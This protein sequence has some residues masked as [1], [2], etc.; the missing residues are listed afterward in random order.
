MLAERAQGAGTEP[1]VGHAARRDLAIENA[2]LAAD[3]A[4]GVDQAVGRDGL[5]ALERGEH[6]ALGDARGGEVEDDRRRGLDR[7]ADRDRVG[8]EAPVDAAER[9]HDRPRH[10]RHEM[11]RDQ[12]LGGRHLRVVADAAEM[13]GVA[14]R[15]RGAAEFLRPRDAEAGGG[16]AD[17][18]AEPILS[19]EHGEGAAVE[20]RLDLAVRLDDAVPHPFDVAGHADDAVAVVAGER[21][22]DQV[23]A[24]RLC[25]LGRRADPLEHLGAT[26]VRALSAG[27]RFPENSAM[28]PA[29]TNRLEETW[30]GIATA[31]HSGERRYK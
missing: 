26:S 1:W 29:P 13:S 22:L 11:Q 17:H 15:D 6:L 19:V 2:G 16:G 20:H 8:R 28:R 12:P 14:K 24:D 25:L 5:P 21:R 7:D 10:H 31:V 9:R 18:L 30:H 23:M 3:L 27:T 4:V